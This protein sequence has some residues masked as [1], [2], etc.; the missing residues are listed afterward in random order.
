MIYYKYNQIAK[1]RRDRSRYRYT[2]VKDHLPSSHQYIS[3]WNP[4]KFIKWADDIGDHTR[5]LIIRVLE[6][7]QYPEQSYR[8]CAG[9]LHFAKK[10][11]NQ[12]LDNACRRALEFGVHNYNIVKTILER[13]LDRLQEE[14]I[15]NTDKLPD[16]TNI[17]GTKYYK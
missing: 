12:R 8:S 4:D 5:E 9:I 16:H 14:D 13:G 6:K 15:S 3:D 7:K 11:G 2:T 10:V 1:H 17:R